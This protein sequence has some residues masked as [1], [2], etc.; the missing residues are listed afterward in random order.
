MD[1]VNLKI[2]A[3]TLT[4]FSFISSF[5]FK[6]RKVSF[7]NLTNS[8]RNFSVWCQETVT[9]GQDNLPLIKNSHAIVKT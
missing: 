6:V 4:R 3:V 8:A 1:V 5:I 7:V 2:M 9:K